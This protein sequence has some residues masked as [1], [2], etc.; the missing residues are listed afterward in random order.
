MRVLI[1]QNPLLEKY[2]NKA[3]ESDE[4]ISKLHDS[5]EKNGV[6]VDK[7]YTLLKN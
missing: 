6:R 5:I 1:I 3:L 7:H 4:L 2:Q